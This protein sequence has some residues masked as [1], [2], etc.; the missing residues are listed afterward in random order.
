MSY[1]A[2]VVAWLPH[3]RIMMMNILRVQED[4]RLTASQRSLSYVIVDDICERTL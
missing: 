1:F 4:R 2:R 3:G